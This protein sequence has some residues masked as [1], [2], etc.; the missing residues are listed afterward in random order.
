M[1]TRF[2]HGCG[3]HYSNIFKIKGYDKDHKISLEEFRESYDPTCAECRWGYKYPSNDPLFHLH[4]W[5][6]KYVFEWNLWKFPFYGIS[7]YDQY[8]TLTIPFLSI[9]WAPLEFSDIRES[10]IDL[11]D[12]YPSKDSDPEV[13]YLIR[14]AY[15]FR[16]MYEKQ[17]KAKNESKAP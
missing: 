6:F 3:E 14:V 8:Y 11:S 9:H 2:K 5:N 4:W 16:R 10:W 17:L 15:R 7:H 12:Y 13:Q 1:R